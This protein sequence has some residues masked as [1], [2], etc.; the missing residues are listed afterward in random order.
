MNTFL[1]ECVACLQGQ[2]F[3]VY[4]LPNEL[5]V[6]SKRNSFMNASALIRESSLRMDR[7]QLIPGTRIKDLTLIRIFITTP[8]WTD[9]HGCT[10]LFPCS[11]LNP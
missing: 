1:N 11:D 7:G 3:G 4:S 5:K 6:L 8:P 9:N 2:V 10:D